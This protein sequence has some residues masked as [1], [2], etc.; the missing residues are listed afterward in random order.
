MLD[1]VIATGNRHKFRELTALL[2]MPGIRWHSLAEFPRLLALR[3]RGTTFD[4]NA[5]SKARAVAR[6]TQLVALADDSGIEVDAL[7]GRPGVR[8][9]RF[10]GTHGEDVTNNVKLLAS[11]QGVPSRKRGAR[12]QCSL[13]LVQGGRVIALT[14]GTW[15]GRIATA[16][17]GRGGFGYDP[18][19]VVPKLGKTVA[20]LGPG[21]KRRYSHR[22]VAARH[23]RRVLARMV[24]VTARGRT[25]S[26]RSRRARVP[27]T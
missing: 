19:V 27:A 15:G 6:A 14:R 26:A 1:I 20:Q 10:A 3:E 11:M 8:S 9:A 2:H 17:R 13:A 25:A 23:M 24:T 21:I 12:Y 16:P 4:A 5:I 18:L 7:G 22:A